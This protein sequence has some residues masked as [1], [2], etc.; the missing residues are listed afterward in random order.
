MAR[1]FRVHVEM[2]N[3]AFKMSGEGS[4]LAACLRALAKQVEHFETLHG[5]RFSVK[6]P[7]GNTVAIG[8]VCNISLK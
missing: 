4:E 2:E 7:N 3:D 6:D 1:G 8:R 5:D